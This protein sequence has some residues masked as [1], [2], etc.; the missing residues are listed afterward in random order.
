MFGVLSI[1]QAND[2]LSHLTDHLSVDGC[3]HL[4]SPQGTL[5]RST[6]GARLRTV[7]PRDCLRR[8]RT[9]LSATPALSRRTARV[10]R[11]RRAR[12]AR[13]SAP[14]FDPTPWKRVALLSGGV[15][16]V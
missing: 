2:L 6:A 7:C 11:S 4:A 14:A 3:V 5:R 8:R 1:T 10:A 9:R 13:R 12:T 16:C 15:L